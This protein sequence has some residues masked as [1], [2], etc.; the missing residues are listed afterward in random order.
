LDEKCLFIAISFY[1]FY[2][3]IVCKNILCES[4]LEVKFLTILIILMTVVLRQNKSYNYLNDT[5]IR[6]INDRYETH[7]I[8]LPH[9]R[10]FLL[11]FALI[12][13]FLFLIR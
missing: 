12:T 3:N 10:H 8:K 2:L 9:L 4:G 7:V 13:V 5:D 6:Q 11:I 1:L